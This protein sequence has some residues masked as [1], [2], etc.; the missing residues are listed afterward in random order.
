MWCSYLD[1]TLNPLNLFQT[2]MKSIVRGGGHLI[3]TDGEVM[4]VES[5]YQVRR[6][7]SRNGGQSHERKG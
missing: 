2:L 7:D 5:P 3:G 4:E 1:F 6:I